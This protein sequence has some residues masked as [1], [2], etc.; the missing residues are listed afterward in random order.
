MQ[1]EAALTMLSGSGIL[2][3]LKNW[4]VL[5]TCWCL[6]MR[7]PS[8]KNE[9]KKKRSNLLNFTVPALHMVV[10]PMSQGNALL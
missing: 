10:S 6:G 8:T 5:N 2:T 9:E 1:L 4:L 3:P 7:S